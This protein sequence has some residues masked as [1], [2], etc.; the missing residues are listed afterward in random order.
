MKIFQLRKDDFAEIAADPVR[1][2]AAIE[3]LTRLHRKLD[4][5]AFISSIVALLLAFD[6]RWGAVCAGLGAMGWMVMAGQIHADLHLLQVMS[7]FYEK[8]SA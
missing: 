8:P 2:Q 6:H 7:K 1:R 5:A 3:R 4:R